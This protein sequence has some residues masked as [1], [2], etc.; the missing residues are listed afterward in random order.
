MF[1]GLYRLE[2][3]ISGLNLFLFPRHFAEIEFRDVEAAVESHC[4]LER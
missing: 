4:K 2:T 1:R 3:F